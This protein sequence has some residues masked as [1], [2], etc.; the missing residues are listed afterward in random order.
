MQN[1]LLFDSL[2]VIF[3]PSD[4]QKSQLNIMLDDVNFKGHGFTDNFF[5]RPK[6]VLPFFEQF[7]LEKLHLLN[8]KVFYIYVRQNS[9]ADRL[10]W[11]LRG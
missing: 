9:L 6:D 10:K 4:E 5:I 11:C 7:S 2:L 1:R 8:S 3:S